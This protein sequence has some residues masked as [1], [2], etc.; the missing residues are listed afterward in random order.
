MKN[1]IVIPM[2]VAVVFG[3]AG[4][5]G[6]MKY[7]ESQGPSFGMQGANGQMI[8]RGPNEGTGTGGN[9]MMG[10]NGARMGFRP[11]SGEII[12]ADDKSITVKTEDGSSKIILIS[13][14]TEIN[15]ADSA[16]ITD[17]KT[18][19]QVAIFGQTNADGSVSAQNIQLNPLGRGPSETPAN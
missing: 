4:F 14:K 6:G 5:F 15:K 16:T 7:Q 12:S 17:L 1:N 11:V 8:I 2:I 10:S 13:D 9:R 3:A 18:G 19:E